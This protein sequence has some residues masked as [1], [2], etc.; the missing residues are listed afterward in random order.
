MAGGTTGIFVVLEGVE[1][2]GKTT[3][4]EL[5]RQRLERAGVAHTVGREPG[6]TELGEALRTI[7]LEFSQGEI[8]PESELLLILAARAAFVRE[9]V[10]PALERGHVVVVDRFELST[11]AYQGFGRGL[12]VEELE[13]LNRFATGGLRPDLTLLLDVPVEQGRA[14]QERDGKERDRF[15]A[16][17]DPFLERVR[18]GY[19]TLARRREDVILL[20]GTLRSEEVHER[21]AGLIGSRFPERFPETFTTAS[22]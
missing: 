3:Q 12:D 9:I 15:E 4:V 5:L 10:G 8:L 6:G 14:R 13:T 21:V 2:A 17:G 22:G 16:G 7:L 20:D 19:N 11:L 18:E 1:G